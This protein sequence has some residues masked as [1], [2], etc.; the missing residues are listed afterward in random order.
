MIRKIATLAAA[1]A[2]AASVLPAVLLA[3]P[4]SATTGDTYVLPPSQYVIPP[5][6]M[7]KFFGSYTLTRVGRGSRLSAANIFITTNSYGDLYGGGM[8]YGY[9]STGAQTDWTNLLYDFRFTGRGAPLTLT[10]WATAGQVARDTFVVTL[11]GWGSPSLGTMT[12]RRLAGGDLAGTIRLLGQTRSYPI[13]FHRT[14]TATAPD[15]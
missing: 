6:V 3:G 4:A 5:Q 10:P 1:L 12:L 13:R 8:F 7:S 9:D 11:Y 14:G 2:A 15:N